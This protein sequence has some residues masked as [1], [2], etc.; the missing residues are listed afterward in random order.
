[1][2]FLKCS[3]TSS[4]L[5]VYCLTNPKHRLVFLFD[6]FD[7][8]YQEAEPRIFA[9]LRGLREAYKYRISYLVF[10][11]DMLSNL[12]E[13]DQ[14]R[15]EFYELL[16]S[17]VMGLKPYAK[18]DA[19]SVLERVAGRNQLTLTAGASR[20]PVRIS[21]GARRIAPGSAAWHHAAQFSRII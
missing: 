12:I 20:L 16:A 19:M 11:R 1:M 6:Q 15:E 2:M 9:N 21:R 4:L 7:D 5:Y 14:A 18:N 3:A 17:N 13:M 10:T 8:V